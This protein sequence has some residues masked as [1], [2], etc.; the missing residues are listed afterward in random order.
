MIADSAMLT[1]K[2]DPTA[3]YRG[4][5]FFLVPFDLPGI[6][7]TRFSDMGWHNATR[8]SIFL[9][10]VHLP[11]DHCLS[12]PGKGFYALVG[13][14]N[15]LRVYL[16]MAVLG[17]AQASLEETINYAKQRTAFGQPIAKFEGVSFKIAEHATY[18]EAARLLCYRALWLADQGIQ[19]I[20]EAAMC[21]WLC[22]VVA[23]NAIHDCLLI[24]GHV[25]YSE[26]Y[27]IEQRLRDAIGF[28]MADGTAQIMKLIIAQQ[29]IGREAR[30]Y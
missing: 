6:T 5:T 29:L 2:T 26:D 23:V 22:P 27:P 28:E 30:P 11:A 1:A 19:P 14:F 18:I 9:D 24:H 17:A 12:E 16:A 20:K 3:G 21:K 10:N 7:R 15:V 13:Q 25:A 8:A 4:I